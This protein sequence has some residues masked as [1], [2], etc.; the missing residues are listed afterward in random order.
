MTQRPVRVSETA[1]VESIT[2]QLEQIAEPLRATDVRIS[3][4]VV[5][6]YPAYEAVT[7]AAVRLG[8]DLVVADCQRQAHPLRWFL[9]F[10]DWELLRHC[11]M[12]VLLIK[13][14]GSYYHA[15]VLAA[16]DPEKSAG[17]PSDLDG[18][19]LAFAS[20]LAGAIG[21]NLHAVHAFNPVPDLSA[22]ELVAPAL[23]AAA[24]RRAEQH[25]HEV[26]DPML[27]EAGVAPAHR[28]I[29]EGFAIDVIEEAVRDS[30]AQIVV[31]GTVSRS[32]AR[33]ILIG[34]TA[35]RMLDRLS[36]DLLIL[37]PLGFPKPAVHEPR[38][39]YVVAAPVR[40]AVLTAVV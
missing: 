2:A 30:R 13:G 4:H 18:Q 10:T 12:P 39:A 33:G 3:I 22:S 23:L 7:R 34:N 38:G 28:H 6:D 1:V 15:P 21:T 5:W 24:E 25:A 19:I 36:C 31:M 9:H 40:P 37:K 17:K 11:P 27:T 16:V 35:E 32:G 8:A 29:G 26:A 20:S 14:P